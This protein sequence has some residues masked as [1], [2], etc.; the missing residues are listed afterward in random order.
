MVVLTLLLLSS[1][2]TIVSKRYK[3]DIWTLCSCQESTVV[4]EGDLQYEVR[5]AH[6]RQWKKRRGNVTVG[7][8]ERLVNRQR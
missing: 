2:A 5:N 6:E 3:R 4:E 8:S 1:L 7:R